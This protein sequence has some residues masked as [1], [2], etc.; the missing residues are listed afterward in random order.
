MSK[1]F[2]FTVFALLIVASMVLT[3][4]GQAATPTPA[5]QKT[6]APTQA[7]KPTTPPPTPTPKPRMGGWL[8]EIVMQSIGS[9]EQALPRLKAG[10]IDIYPHGLGNPEDFKAVKEDSGLTYAA[11][12]G[13]YNEILLNTAEFKDGR[14][15]PF[16]DQQIRQAMQMLI[17]RNYIVQE[18]YGGLAKPRYLPLTTAFPDYAR[19]VDKAREW[20]AKYAYNFDKAKEII[21]ERMQALGAEMND[22]GKW[23]YNGEPVTLTALIRTEDERKEIGDYVS[24]QLEAVGFTVE[25]LYKTSKEASPYWVQTDPQEGTW[26][27]YTGGWV[28]EY[29]DRYEADGISIWDDPAYYGPYL[30]AWKGFDIPKEYKEIGDKLLN[31]EYTNMEERAA[32]VRQAL[33]W[34]MKESNHIWL[35]DQF[36]F[37]P[38]KSNVSVASDL[39]A[40]VEAS[41]T[42][43]YTLRFTDQVGGSMKMGLPSLLVEPVNPVAGSN[44][45]YD[46]MPLTAV[47]DAGVFPNP[48]T[49]LAMPQRIEK[50][51]VVAKKGLPLTK[52]SDW[53]DLQFAD[54]IEVPKDAWVDWDAAAQ[55]FITAGEMNAKIEEAKAKMAKLEDKAT[56]VASGV[57]VTALNE[58]AVQQFLSDLASAAGYKVDVAAAFASDDAKTA[59]TDKVKEIGAAKDPAKA[60][61]AYGVEFLKK[62][63]KEVAAAAAMAERKPYTEAKV[64]SVVYYPA[65]LFDKVKWQDGT[66][67]SV[68]DFVLRMIMQFDPG[69]KD[70]PIYDASMEANVQQFLSH[71]KGVRIVSTDPLVIETYD[72]SYSPDAENTVTTWWPNYGFATAPWHDLALG[73]LA[74]KN[75]ELAFTQD[76]ANELKVEWMNYLAGPSLKILKKYLDQASADGFVPYAPTLGQYV[77]TDQAKAAY[78][79][80]AKFYKANGHFVVG[81]GPYYIA[82]VDTTNSVLVLKHYDAYPDRADKWAGFGKPKIAEVEVEGAG[83]VVKGQKATFDVYVTFE[84]EP[85]PADE[86]ES[87]KYLVFD[88]SG[89]LLTSGD[90]AMVED[91]HYQVVL[92]EDATQAFA[93]GSAKLEVAVSSKMVS[94]PGFGSLEFV[95]VAP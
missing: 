19:F 16:H 12:Y 5:P 69:K 41:K 63:V 52:S 90:A 83:Q 62:Q 60:L 84:G 13:S 54:K 3:A 25:R 47:G 48:F 64:K 78:A 59:L 42:W 74:E 20:E 18:I 65:D 46:Q 95:V 23:V 94:I 61:A 21:T 82:Q 9:D 30:A 57:D 40:G 75:K 76:K 24:N 10:E 79:N 55:K 37:A 77:N 86:I 53:I 80:L 87:V 26:S 35:V 22:E 34:T 28:K 15:N 49:G 45:V 31:T 2:W 93:E 58:A 4:C 29:I 89:N 33:D 43:A 50:A 72:D 38:M 88:A 6:E 7:P 1:R 17:D 51:E 73:I 81:S 44:W 36:S 11:A 67:L 39:A 68:A 32:L 85:Y 91:G 27:F 8:D 71:F 92:S 70:S 14:L 56:E 66:P